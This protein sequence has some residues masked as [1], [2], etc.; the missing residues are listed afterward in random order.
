MPQ[1]FNVKLEI[2]QRSNYLSARCVDVPGL[3]LAGATRED[4]RRRAMPAIKQLLKVNRGLDVDVLPT[5][6]LAEFR[7]KVH[8]A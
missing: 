1:T 3:H 4:L 6:D 5:D 7:I 8:A 2:Q